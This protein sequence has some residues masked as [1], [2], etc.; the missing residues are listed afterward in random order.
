MKTLLVFGTY[1]IDA[2]GGLIY[3]VTLYGQTEQNPKMTFICQ[4]GIG[5][6]SYSSFAEKATEIYCKYF[7][8]DSYNV[9]FLSHLNRE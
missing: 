4:T 8:C 9:V 1:E 2:R 5:C 7:E 3:N 6:M